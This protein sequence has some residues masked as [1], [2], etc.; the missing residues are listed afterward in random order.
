M[1]YRNLQ[2][3]NDKLS[4]LGYGCMRFPTKNGSIDEPRTEKQ[5][6]SAIEQGVNY[7][8]TAYVYPNSEKI[9]GKI[10]S[11]GYY[12]K[13]KIATKLPLHMI[14][15]KN[16]IERIFNEQLLRL[17]TNRIDYYLIHN[18]N[19]FENWLKLKEM[20]IKSFI[21]K[22]REEGRIVNI[23]FSFHGN[24]QTFKKVADDYPWDFCQIQYNY[25]DE[26]FQAGKEGL[27][28]A[29]TKGMGII[30][31]EPLRGGTLVNKMPLPAQK[32]I[33]GFKENRTPAEWGLR[34]VWNHP[35]VT[36]VLSGMNDEKHIE[37]NIR[38]AG[39]A[40]PN[41]MSEEELAMLRAVK[42]EFEA[43]I[44]VPCTGCAYCMPC[45]H[46]VDIP[47]CFAL[48]NS[49]AMF[50]GIF[51]VWFYLSGTSKKSD[52]ATRASQCKNCGLCERNC[53]Q[54]L[55]IRKHLQ[56]TARNMEKI[57]LKVISGIADRV[58]Y[59]GRKNNR[60]VQQF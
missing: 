31:M 15:S 21:N 16:D 22:E 20:D 42:K 33:S 51:P 30:V 11:K 40:L 44:K 23:G 47:Q 14:Q 36:V 53:P 38:I 45:P 43:K 58:T 8:D 19:T 46:G 29:A 7:F 57:H 25:V 3:T 24:V 37:E 56:E 4:I 32:I 28:Y 6:L 59:K 60:A 5:I 2:N 35:E 39:S 48:Y 27:G 18:I 52:R 49:K 41:S 9:L 54:N 55:P 12:D 13:V 26:N 50:G 10:L 34:W 1:L 17:Q